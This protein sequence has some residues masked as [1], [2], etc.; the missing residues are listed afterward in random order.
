MGVSIGMKKREIS[1]NGDDNAAAITTDSSTN[2]S[3]I[4][5][6]M[7]KAEETIG[8]YLFGNVVEGRST[9]NNVESSPLLTSNIWTEIQAK[10]Q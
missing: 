1:V 10:E 9:S 6:T 4:G 7:S 3:G 5:P 2:S 8:G